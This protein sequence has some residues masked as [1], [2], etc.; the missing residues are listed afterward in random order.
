MRYSELT[1]INRE[2]VK[3]LKVAWTFHTG[4]LEGRKGKTIE[5]TPI[6]ID[7]VMYVTTGYLRVVALDA[8][9]GKQLWQFDPLTDHP[10]AHSPGVRRRQS[11]LRV[12]VGW[13]AR[14]RAPRSFTARRTDD[15]FRW[16]RA[17]GKLDP[18]F[19]T[20]GILNLRDGLDPKVRRA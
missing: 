3:R 14:W 5:C 19:G 15:C 8:A 2:N 6:V 12:L 18:K 1:Q 20:S 11:R 7:G 10:F 17:T 13:Q 4:E 9:T 16:M